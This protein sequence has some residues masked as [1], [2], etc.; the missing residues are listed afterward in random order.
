MCPPLP[1]GEV[2]PGSSATRWERNMTERT[3]AGTGEK[4][5]EGNKTTDESTGDELTDKELEKVSGGDGNWGAATT[6][7]PQPIAP[8]LIGVKIS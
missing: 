4:T 8:P 3:G 5:I 7:K 1:G 6:L 2:V